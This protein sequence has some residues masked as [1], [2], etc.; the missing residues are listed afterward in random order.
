MRV[1]MKCY[2]FIR[3]DLRWNIC[4]A[5]ILTEKFSGEYSGHDEKVYF[6]N[7]PACS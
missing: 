6:D 2:R 1:I 7:A 5:F 4:C 3:Y